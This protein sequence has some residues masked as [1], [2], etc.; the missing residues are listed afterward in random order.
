LRYIPELDGALI[1][2]IPSDVSQGVAHK[3]AVLCKK[4]GIDIYGIV[5]NMSAFNCP[6]CHKEINILQEGGGTFLSE[7]LGVPFLGKIPMDKRVAVCADEGE[8]FVHRH[9]DWEGSIMLHDAAKK[10]DAR[11][12]GAG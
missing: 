1:V 2:T 8:P 3:A 10:I 4:A 5:E 12:F 11:L 7:K 9:P 6:K